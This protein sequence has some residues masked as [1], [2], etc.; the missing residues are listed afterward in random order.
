M[1]GQAVSGYCRRLAGGSC[2]HKGGQSI[3]REHPSPAGASQQ[4]RTCSG[5]FCEQP[6][7]GLSTTG[8]EWSGKDSPHAAQIGCGSASERDGQ[9][10]I[11]LGAHRDQSR[12]VPPPALISQDDKEGH[13]RGG[14]MNQ[15]ALFKRTLGRAAEVAPS[16]TSLAVSIQSNRRE[17]N[18]DVL[19]E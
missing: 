6:R 19:G 15:P 4:P 9:G 1:N 3:A 13:Q 5:S 18:V 17:L 14:L 16:S 2:A 8:L 12:S 7:H 11:N 10:A